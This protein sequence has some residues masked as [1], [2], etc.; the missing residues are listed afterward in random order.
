MGSARPPH[1][2]PKYLGDVWGGRALDRIYY[3]QY[4]GEEYSRRRINSSDLV[5]MGRRLYYKKGPSYVIWWFLKQMWRARGR[6][7]KF[8]RIYRFHHEIAGVKSKNATWKILRRLEFYGLIDNLGGW[9]KPAV[10]D[11]TIVEGSIDWSRVRTRDQVIKPKSKET[12][13]KSTTDN[14]PQPVIRIIKIAKD[15]IRRGEKW[16]AVDLLAHTLFGIRETGV[17]IGRKGDIFI[18]FERKTDKMHMWKSRKLAGILDKLGI[19]D[20]FLAFHRK[21]EASDIIKRLFGSHD[22]AR[23]V[24]YLIKEKGWIEYLD[25]GCWYYRLYRDPLTGSWFISIYVR[26]GNRLEEVWRIPESIDEN[27]MY[28]QRRAGAIVTREHVKEENEETYF[29]RS[30]GLF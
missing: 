9:Y 25:P 23:R 7:I 13:A 14:I 11:D 22:V 27:K 29:N 1:P 17:L 10:L 26:Q 16:R 5:E 28:I 15:L 24:H 12:N 18:I 2:G 4:I 3:R 30:K 19:H 21:Y 6:P 8:E 20:E